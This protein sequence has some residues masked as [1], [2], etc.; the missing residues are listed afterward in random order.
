VR[1][2]AA[3]TASVCLPSA[4][5][6]PVAS[7]PPPALEEASRRADIRVVSIPQGFLLVRYSASFLMEL[8]ALSERSG[9]LCWPHIMHPI[10]QLLPH[11]KKVVSKKTNKQ[12]VT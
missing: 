5:R 12:R 9:P 8:M 3:A 7:Q 11:P 1:G 4:L 2:E 10:N 6:R